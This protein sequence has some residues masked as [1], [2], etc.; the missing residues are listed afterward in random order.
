MAES[1]VFDDNNIEEEEEEEEYGDEDFVTDEYANQ[2]EDI[3]NLNKSNQK[4]DEEDDNIVDINQ[5]EEIETVVIKKDTN[6]ITTSGYPIIS[7]I[8]HTKIYSTLCDYI[9][10][11]QLEV[12]ESME[13]E[14]EVLSGDTFRIARFWINN[15]RRWPIPLTIKRHIQGNIY[16]DVDPNNLMFMD[17]IGFKDDN[18]DTHLFYQNFHPEPYDNSC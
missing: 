10:K 14:P 3:D 11:S 16:E 2:N 18:D 9:S 6:K 4:G 13:N 17:E 15:R 5:V 7:F 8:E 12:P 1:N